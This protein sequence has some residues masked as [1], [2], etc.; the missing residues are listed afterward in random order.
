MRDI[1]DY[2]HMTRKEFLESV[3]IDGTLQCCPGDFGLKE[4]E[5]TEYT[6]DRCWKQSAKNVEFKDDNMEE[7]FSEKDLKNGMVV[8][9]RNGDRYIV[10]EDRIISYLSWLGLDQYYDGLTFNNIN[11]MS[12]ENKTDFDIV[13]IFTTLGKSLYSMVDDINIRTIW[14]RSEVDWSKV[15]VDTKIESKAKGG[16]W[17]KRYFAKYENGKIFA[18]INGG[19]SFSTDKCNV[20]ECVRLYKEKLE[21]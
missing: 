10:F 14:Q 5:C 18:W 20:W 17:C 21:D 9:L 8:E 1:N 15:A 13:R 2:T 11:H 6:C 4:L 7:E 16:G 12:L 19:T 3:K